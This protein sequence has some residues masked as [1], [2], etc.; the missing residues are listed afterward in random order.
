[1]FAVLCTLLATAAPATLT[2]NQTGRLLDDKDV[3]VESA[4]L[5][6]TFSLFASEVPLG[7]ETPAWTET[8]TVPVTHGIYAVMLGDTA[9]GKAALPAS[10]FPT[11]DDRFLEIA[12]GGAPLSPRLRLGAVPVAAVA[13][14]LDCEGCVGVAQLGFDPTP[15]DG[16][17]VTGKLADGAV[18]TPKL[19]DGAVTDAKIAAVA[20][21][22]ITGTLTDAQLAGLSASKLTGTI[23]DAQL[24]ALSASK[25]TGLVA[26]AQLAGLSASKLTGQL[27]DAQI[28]GVSATKLSDQVQDAQIASLSAAKLTGTLPLSAIPPIPSSKLASPF[29]LPTA[30]IAPTSPVTGTTYF[31]TGEGALKVWN[32]ARWVYVGS[33]CGDSAANAVASCKAIKANCGATADGVYWV[34]GPSGPVQTWCDMTTDGGGWTVCAQKDFAVQG[35]K[36]ALKELTTTY[37]TPGAKTDFGVACHALMKQASGGG[38]V[39]F[40]MK[41]QSG[42]WAW[43]WPL[44]TQEY[45]D[46][47]TGASGTRCSTAVTQ[48]KS[49]AL[50]STLSIGGHYQNCHLGNWG[51]AWITNDYYLNQF[52]AALNTSVLMEVGN[53][54]G[55]H[56]TGFSLDGSTE[57]Y[58]SQGNSTNVA[59]AYPYNTAE[60]DRAAITGA[61]GC[62]INNVQNVVT[63][64][65][66]ER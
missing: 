65:F 18:T 9:G 12:I 57:V 25:L 44:S 5:S 49:S 21:S 19:F 61:G 35:V 51:S 22:K 54:W 47:H 3:P 14:S 48:F 2:L 30:T 26:D 52:G 28:A 6:M 42:K 31:D 1:M 4:G 41:L 45:F 55:D 27:T 66:R 16:S 15:A 17:V 40:G 24:A 38:T 7:Q 8:Y 37:G 39:E 23:A 29:V 46:V 13:R 58:N 62:M 56:V 34:V 50:S 60:G 10:A 36:L 43:V 63:L 64:M 11:S 53:A 32:G 33:K 20:A 59:C